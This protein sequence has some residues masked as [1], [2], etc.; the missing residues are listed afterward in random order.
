MITIIRSLLL[1]SVVWFTYV[2]GIIVSQKHLGFWYIIFF[3][4]QKKAHIMEIQLN[5]G[6]VADKVINLVKTWRQT[7]L[8]MS[9]N[10]VLRTYTNTNSF[11]CVR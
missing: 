11:K 6:S 10:M 5:G 3:C 2:K 4:R 8:S 1:Y 7:T 9:G